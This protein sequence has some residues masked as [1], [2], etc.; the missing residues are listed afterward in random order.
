MPLGDLIQAIVDNYVPEA[1]ASIVCSSVEPSPRICGSWVEVLPDLLG[2]DTNSVLAPG[3]RAFA[4][5]ILSRG[6]KHR[7]SIASGL[8][9][10]QQALIK[11][12]H[13]LEA[14]YNAFPVVLA[15]LSRKPSF[16]AKEEW[17]T[18]PF[19]ETS[20]SPVQALMSEAAAIPE[21]LEKLDS[22]GADAVACEAL[23]DFETILSRFSEHAAAGVKS[24]E[25]KRLSVMIC[26]SIEYLMQEEMKLFGPTSVILPLRT[27]YETFKASGVQ[28]I[29]E[30]AWCKRIVGD[31]RNRGY[32]FM[33]LLLG[34]DGPPS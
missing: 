20:P 8:E 32:G 13:A 18:V 12:N 14:P 3:I 27:A 1:D 11:V 6:P 21:I 25:A 24:D 5:T 7:V 17:K 30:L 29:E 28:A 16:L 22:N 15:F 33:M 2:N 34:V 9:A 19:L 26:Q 4:L 10:Y 31:I 23:A